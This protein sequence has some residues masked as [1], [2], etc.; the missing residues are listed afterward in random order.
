VRNPFE[1]SGG[2]FRCALHTHTTSSD[3]ELP[4]EFLVRH[5]EWAGFDVLAI[6][7]HWVRTEQRS[8]ER[9]LVLPGVELDARLEGT[10]RKAHVLGFGVDA[11]P[12]RPVGEFPTL[13][14]TVAWIERHGGLPY[15]AHPY[16]SGLRTHEFERCD[17]LLGLE[18]FNAGC[19]LEAGRGVS[20]VHWDEALESGRPWL[21]IAVDDCHHPGFDSALAWTWVRA[22]KRSAA[23]VFEALREGSFYSSTGPEVERVDVHGNVVEVRC[24]PAQ[25]ITLMTGR[26]R[27][28][29]VVA[30]RLG[31][32]YRGEILERSAE[33]GVTAARLT[34]PATAPYARLEVKDARGA[35]AWTNALWTEASH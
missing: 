28:A 30:G 2:W 25:R 14:E 15:L 1:A 35:T 12:E 22:Q 6:T 23:A 21:G 10:E 17:G 7:D 19:E 29:S 34:A 5:Y 20:S 9:L 3:G 24:S 31:Y 27:G 32:H 33:G 4:P 16:W 8:T 26:T 11:A 13:D 18:V